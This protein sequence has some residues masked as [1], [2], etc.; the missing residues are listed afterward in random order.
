MVGVEITTLQQRC[1]AP[2]CQGRSDDSRPK[3]CDILRP[4]SCLNVLQHSN[5]RV[6]DKYTRHYINKPVHLGIIMRT[7]ELPT[8]TMIHM[9]LSVVV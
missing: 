2:P 3:W 9:V 4:I 1:K 5:E 7:N 8:Q 6:Y